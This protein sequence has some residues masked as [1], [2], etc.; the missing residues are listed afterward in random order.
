VTFGRGTGR[1]LGPRSEQTCVRAA[2]QTKGKTESGRKKQRG[3]SKEEEKVRSNQS[4]TERTTRKHTFQDAFDGHRLLCHINRHGE[5]LL[6]LRLELHRRHGVLVPNSNSTTHLCSMPRRLPSPLPFS[7]SLSS[8]PLAFLASCMTPAYG[9]ALPLLPALSR[10]QPTPSTMTMSCLSL[11]RVSLPP[12]RP[13]RGQSSLR[14]RLLRLAAVSPLWQP[15]SCQWR[16]PSICS[17]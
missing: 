14:A 17:S 13:F 16:N 4:A 15:V 10:K 8:P 9:S 5:H 6:I 2:R 3:R 11:R 1:S 7:F 12:Y